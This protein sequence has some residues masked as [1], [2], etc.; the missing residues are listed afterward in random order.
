MDLLRGRQSVV[1]SLPAPV[2][3]RLVLVPGLLQPGLAHLQQ[4]RYLLAHLE[5]VPARLQ[6][7]RRLWSR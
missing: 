7:G 6:Q 3:P 1:A 4:E 5:P 2:L